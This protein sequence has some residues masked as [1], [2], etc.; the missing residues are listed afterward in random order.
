[1][2]LNETG[3]LKV[4]AHSHERTATLKWLSTFAAV[5]FFN[6]SIFI[7]LQYQ[8]KDSH[9]NVNNLLNNNLVSC[10]ICLI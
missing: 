6:R 3:Y 8:R 2:A 5:N 1:M 7:S 9:R 4:E 10:E